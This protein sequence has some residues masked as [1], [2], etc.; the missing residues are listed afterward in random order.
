MILTYAPHSDIM[1]ISNGDIKMKTLEK[2]KLNRR[3]SQSRGPPAD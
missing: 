1:V 2:P 3:T